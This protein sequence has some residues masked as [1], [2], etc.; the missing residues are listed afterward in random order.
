MRHDGNRPGGATELALRLLRGVVVIREQAVAKACEQPAAAEVKPSAVCVERIDLVNRPGDP[1]A[2]RPGH[3]QPD[4][5][6]D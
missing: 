1:V 6:Q 5:E 3:D 4:G 2:E